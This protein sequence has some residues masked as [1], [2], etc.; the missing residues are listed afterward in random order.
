MEIKN[1]ADHFLKAYLELEDDPNFFPKEVFTDDLLIAQQL[2]ESNFDRHATSHAGAVGVM[3]NMPIS[4]KDDCLFLEKLHNN[5]I[6]NYQGPIYIGNL[7]NELKG[8]QTGKYPDLQGD[9]RKD[10]I[11]YLKKL[12]PE[13]KKKF[14][15][16]ILSTPQIE[17]TKLLLQHNPDYS[18]ALGKIYHMRLWH[19]DYGYSIGQSDV[20]KGNLQSAH[21]KLLGSYNAGPKA[22]KIPFDKWKNYSWGKEPTIYVQKILNYMNRLKN[23]RSAMPDYELDSKDNA[24]AMRTAREMNKVFLSKDSKHTKKE[25]LDKTMNHILSELQKAQN[26]TGR[27]LTEDE[28]IEVFKQ[29]EKVEWIT[30]DRLYDKNESPR[31]ATN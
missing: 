14:D 18:K 1:I 15:K 17:T 29:F 12:I 28:V 22:S 9:K 6:I 25:L 5:S 13:K 19:K 7:E 4:I 10:R 31:V 2:Q 8:L 20:K 3:Q 11:E 24:I 27:K 23:I 30:D 16:R 26:I 21:I